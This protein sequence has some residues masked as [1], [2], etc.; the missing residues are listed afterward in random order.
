MKSLAAVA[1]A[2]ALSATSGS[3]QVAVTLPPATNSA[4]G[5]DPIMRITTTFRLPVATAET[6]AMTDVKAA[7]TVRRTLYGMADAEC[8]TLSEVFKAE[9]RLNSV[10]M[11]SLSLPPNSSPMGMMTATAIYELKRK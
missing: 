2:V 8:A 4:F 3:A 11:L 9:C 6:Q 5:P 7:E 10:T 1:I